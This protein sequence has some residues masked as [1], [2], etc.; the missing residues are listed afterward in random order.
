MKD[1]NIYFVRFP[2]EWPWL[3]QII[4]E[5]K[6]LTFTKN[7]ILTGKNGHP[8]TGIAYKTMKAKTEKRMTIHA[9]YW[10]NNV[11]VSGNSFFLIRIYAK[12]KRKDP[13]NLKV[14]DKFICD[15]LQSIGVFDDDGWDQMSAGF[16]TKFYIDKKNPRVD[17]WIMENYDIDID[18]DPDDINNLKQPYNDYQ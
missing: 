8:V 12:N 3:N 10:L 17:V 1:K 5:A 11:K 13:N 18:M 15:L 7:G 2:G 14:V 4:T 6:K 16:L 9:N